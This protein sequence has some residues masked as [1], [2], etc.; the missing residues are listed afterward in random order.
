MKIDRTWA[1]KTF[2]KWQSVL[3]LQDWDMELYFVEK[4]W[5]KTG[6][7]KIDEDNK[8]AILMLN[9]FNPKSLNFEEVII[10]ELIHVK[11]WDMDQMLERMI[12]KVFGN[13]DDDPKYQ[14]AMEEFF[15]VLE[16]TT[17]D[18]AKGFVAIGAENKKISMGKVKK[19]VKA[20][21]NK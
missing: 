3:R 11:L 9:D 19:E 7:I 13:D 15:R 6:D 1:E 18:L 20:E 4:E 2:R 12:I 5:R 10:H 17:E 8:C 16:K 14:F 21:I